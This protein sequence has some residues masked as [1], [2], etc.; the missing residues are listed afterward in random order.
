MARAAIALGVL[1]LA[2]GCAPVEA[3]APPACGSVSFGWDPADDAT[4]HA[5]PDDAMTVDDA[6][7]ATGV[8]VR[9]GAPAWVGSLT[10]V[11]A[12][13]VGQLDGLGGFG[14]LGQVLLRFSGDVGDLGGP[15][16][17]YAPSPDA[18]LRLLDLERGVDVPFELTSSED[19]EQILLQPMTPLAPGRRHGVV[20]TTAHQ[21][22]DGACVAPSPA[23][24]KL[25]GGQV[26]PGDVAGARLAARLRRLLDVTGLDRGEVSAAVV[27]TTDDARG[28]MQAAA[29]DARSRAGAWRQRPSCVAEA[30]W[31]RCEGVM[32]GVDFR[33]DGGLL[34]ARPWA[35]W[36]LPVTVL[37]PLD[38]GPAP[39]MLYG[40]GINSGRGEVTALAEQ[41][42]PLRVAL[43]AT[44]A[45]RH[46]DHPTA[47]PDVMDAL[48]FL[49]LDLYGGQV[50]GVA[51][52]SSFDQTVVDRMQLLALLQQDPDVDGDGLA[53]LDPTRM[54]YTGVSLGGLLGPGLLA[55]GVGIDAALLPVGGGHLVRFVTDVSLGPVT[56]GTLLSGLIGDELE[57]QTFLA[58]AQAVIDGSDPA[59]WAT[60][61]LRDRPFGDAPPHLLLPVANHD[62]V[63]PPPAGRMLARALGLPHVAPVVEPVPLLGPVI[64]APVIGA[65]EG[66]T[67]GFFQYGVVREGGVE[68]LADHVTTVFSDE[69]LRQLRAWWT[70]WLDEPAPRIID[71]YAP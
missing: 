9:V 63:V 22:V 21:A 31:R 54:G 37:L 2:V 50:D 52:R 51:L 19:G 59:N 4:L 36:D 8:R 55:R 30:N 33:R 24:W 34:Q 35:G 46:G 47:N 7:S 62:Q 10:P 39:G 14:R 43:V 69:H 18:P 64:D 58:V 17:G 40:H 70:S 44:D 67:W 57:W 66:R 41:L 5:F 13:V 71:P 6:S 60:E 3:E 68:V 61:V 65:G 38:A 23:L 26:R 56:A 12:D 49:G 25:L 45:M 27:F 32:R 42:L 20:L 11:V 48:D 28:P 16:I 1:S 29:E 15:D 53:D